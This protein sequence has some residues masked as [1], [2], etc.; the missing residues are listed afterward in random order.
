MDAIVQL[1]RNAMCCVKDLQLFTDTFPFLY[2]PAYLAKFYKFPAPYMSKTTPLELLISFSQ[3]YAAFS[4]CRSGYKLIF[5]QGI[6]KLIRLGRIADLFAKHPVSVSKKDADDK[7]KD[8]DK[9]TNKKTIAIITSS[10]LHEGNAALKNTLIGL[11]VLPIGI[12]FFWLFANS[13]HLTEAGTIGGLPALIHALI[14]MEIALLPLLYYMIKDGAAAIRKGGRI[15]ALIGKFNNKKQKDL[16]KNWISF[17]T[18]NF[19]IVRDWTPF[20]TL[21]ATSSADIMAEDKM[22]VKEVEAVEKH[23]KA[24]SSSPDEVV[25]K[26]DAAGD[27]ETVAKM[28]N[29]EGYR[30]F[31]YFVFNFIAFYGY[32][33]GIIV[34]YYDQEGEKQPDF[35]RNLK[36]GYSNADA[37]WGG[38]FAGDMMWTLE[39][40]AILVFPLIFK[41]I[42]QSSSVG[43]TKTD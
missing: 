43:K 38:N 41:R 17:E 29:L 25:L 10:I 22:L 7:D 37:D 6:S 15:R 39:P 19:F 4:C 12:A 42:V 3:L 26:K 27:L 8:V 34:Y 36:L 18:Y 28:S 30:E 2:D 11:C 24:K 35:V 23:V 13:L 40:I 9:A 1:V 16:D 33:L 31:V 14:V 5:S 32:L 21:S 20:W